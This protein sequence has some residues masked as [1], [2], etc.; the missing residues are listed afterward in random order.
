M[1]DTAPKSA[2]EIA[3]E[4]LRQKDKE[5]GIVEQAV[6]EAQKAAIAE[7]RRVHESKVAEAKILHQ[8]KLAT[9]ADWEERERIEADHRRELERLANELDRRITRIREGR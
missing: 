1:S 8:S 9:V 4:R 7:A 6:P 3:M 5:Q 2:Y